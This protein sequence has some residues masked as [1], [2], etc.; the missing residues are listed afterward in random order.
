MT[1]P[2]P[3]DI[4]QTILQ[5]G[6]PAPDI[7]LISGENREI[8]LEDQR[9]TPVILAF[10]PADFSPVCSDQLSLYNEIL[11]VFEQY[12]ARLFGIS[13][14][15]K[16]SHRAFARENNLHFQLLSDF[17]PKGEVARKYGVYD[18]RKGRAVRALFV[19]DSQGVI[20]W[21]Y[22]PPKG[23]NPGAEGIIQALESLQAR[24]VH[25]G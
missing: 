19:I 17:E 3:A 6:T 10:Y 16:W 1:R 4:Q 2:S 5:P 14:D 7:D 23:T 18:A 25:H 24:E 8:T 15:G 9:G 21:S 11:P 13:V 20:R 22:A 12:G